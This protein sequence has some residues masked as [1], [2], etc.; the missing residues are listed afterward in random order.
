MRKRGTSK[1]QGRPK[2]KKKKT[3]S[4]EAAAGQNAKHMQ[5]MQAW[6]QRSA[7][8]QKIKTTAKVCGIAEII[9]KLPF[10]G[11]FAFF[12]SFLQCVCV[13]FAL[14]FDFVFCVLAGLCFQ[15]C[16]FL[17]VF[18]ILAGRGFQ[19]CVFLHFGRP[20]D[21]DV[22]PF[23]ILPG[24]GRFSPKKMQ[25]QCKAQFKQASKHKKNAKQNSSRPA[26]TKKM[27][28]A[29]AKTRQHKKCKQQMQT[30]T[31]HIQ[32]VRIG[33]DKCSGVDQT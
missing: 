29:N 13:V 19:A 7:K 25:K 28:T 17:H 3:A 22:P 10:P 30:K 8:T 4:L 23:R 26:N 21:L 27:Q 12:A 9:K 31:Q 6:K 14:F 24:L 5:K 11:A 16:I 2:C 1:S 32:K 33:V 20:W 18:C 15:A